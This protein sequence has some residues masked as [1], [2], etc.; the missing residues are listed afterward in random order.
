MAPPIEVTNT[1]QGRLN[2]L[3]WLLRH[4]E[5]FTSIHGTARKP[6]YSA[7]HKVLIGDVYPVVLPLLDFCRSV[8]CLPSWANPDVKCFSVTIRRR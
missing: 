4:K 3:K 7:S 2:P 1:P 8:P 5:G 6:D